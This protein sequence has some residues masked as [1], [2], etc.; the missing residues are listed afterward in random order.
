[1]VFETRMLIMVFETRMLKTTFGSKR[2]AVTGCQRKL[3]VDN[4]YNFQSSSGIAR[5]LT[6]MGIDGIVT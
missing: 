1:M 5:A 4:V 6:S 3:D 2:E